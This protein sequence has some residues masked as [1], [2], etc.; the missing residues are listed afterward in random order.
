MDLFADKF[1]REEAEEYPSEDTQRRL[2]FDK[3]P[4]NPAATADIN[5]ALAGV[6][7]EFDAQA[8][9]HLAIASFECRGDQCLLLAAENGVELE[10]GEGNVMQARTPVEG[11]EL[12]RHLVATAWWKS[13]GLQLGTFGAEYKYGNDNYALYYAYFVPSEK[14]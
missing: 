10:A 6:L 11:L 4:L 13:S 14:G 1:A 8:T 9:Q 5:A 12:I 3:K 2:A 7:L